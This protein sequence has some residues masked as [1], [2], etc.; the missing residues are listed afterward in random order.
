MIFQNG[1][2]SSPEV[3]MLAIVIKILMLIVILVLLVFV[4]S[5]L[6]ENY[7]KHRRLNKTKSKPMQRKAVVHIIRKKPIG[8]RRIV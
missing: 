8:K 3:L 5:R 7:L 6:V 4:F 1:F 2:Q